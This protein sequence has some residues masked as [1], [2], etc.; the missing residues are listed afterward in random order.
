MDASARSPGPDDRLDRP[1]AGL[2]R[3]RVALA[4]SAL[5]LLCFVGLTTFVLVDPDNAMD[6]ALARVHSG[7][8]PSWLDGSATFV[9]FLGVTV[10][11]LA[12]LP[13]AVALWFRRRRTAALVLVGGYATAMVV[14]VA[15]KL[16]VDRP[17]PVL[18]D[19]A[20][21]AADE[22][23]FPSTSV[24]SCVVFWGLVLTFALVS[25]PASRWRRP[26]AVLAVM[27]MA[28]IGPSRLVVGDHWPTDVLG[29][30]LLGGAVL[31][32]LLWIGARRATPTELPERSI[33]ERN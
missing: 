16:L 20:G 27:L 2:E 31:G 15:V 28:L 21:V 32:L 9:R 18:A 4:A 17:R 30:Y 14:S 22:T 25:D 8:T 23:S 3:G 7:T 19:M 10:P 33:R 29:G 1:P 24:V 11:L 26:P 12:T 6:T 13:L 5:G